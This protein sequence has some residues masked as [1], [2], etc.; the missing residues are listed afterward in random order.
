MQVTIFPE[1]LKNL[2]TDC[3]I[4]YIKWCNVVLTKKAD[5]ITLNQV[6]HFHNMIQSKLV[7]EI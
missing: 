4:L 6:T 2:T 5:E 1:F 7:W 3:I